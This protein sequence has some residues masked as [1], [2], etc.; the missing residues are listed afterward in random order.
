MLCVKPHGKKKVKAQTIGVKRGFLIFNIL[1]QID[2]G[3]E[4]QNFVIEGTIF[5]IFNHI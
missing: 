5:A 1:F 2:F 3:I 4:I